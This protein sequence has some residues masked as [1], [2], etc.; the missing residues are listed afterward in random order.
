MEKT[1]KEKPAKEKTAS[2]KPA[3]KKTVNDEPAADKAKIKNISMGS[4]YAED[5]DTSY[6]FYRDILGLVDVNS[7]GDNACYF[8]LGNSQ[9]LY[10]E[11]GFDPCRGAGKTAKTTF[12]FQVESAFEMFGKLKRKGIR[13]VQKEPMKMADNIFWFQCFDPSGNMIEFLGGE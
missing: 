2:E 4:V 5:Y 7:M 13:T 8:E 12:T 1:A 6:R 11:G 3:K 10:L 9:G